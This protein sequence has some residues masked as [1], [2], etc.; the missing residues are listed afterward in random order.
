LFYKN[1]TPTPLVVLSRNKKLV[2]ELV[3]SKPG[4]TTGKSDFN[5]KKE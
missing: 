4:Q 2:L 5:Y 3:Y 1:T